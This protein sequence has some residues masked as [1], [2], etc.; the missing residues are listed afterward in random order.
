[1]SK[2][3]NWFCSKFSSR[4][5]LGACKFSVSEL[6]LAETPRKSFPERVLSCSE[7][8]SS[9]EQGFVVVSLSDSSLQ[10][11]TTEVAVESSSEHSQGSN[12]SCISQSS[13]NT[14]S[15]CSLVAM[16]DDHGS[17]EYQPPTVRAISPSSPLMQSHCSLIAV[18]NDQGSIEY[19]PPS[20]QF[21]TASSIKRM[22]SP[23]CNTTSGLTGR[24]HP[25]LDRLISKSNL[26]L[27]PTAPR[28]R[29][30]N[31]KKVQGSFLSALTVV[32]RRS[33]VAKTAGKSSTR[34][35][36]SGSSP[37][38]TLREYCEEKQLELSADNSTDFSISHKVTGSILS[39]KLTPSS[40]VVD[41]QTEH[42][43]AIA[44]LDKY[45]NEHMQWSERK[46]RST[47]MWSTSGIHI[48]PLDKTSNQFTFEVSA[49]LQMHGGQHF[50]V[51]GFSIYF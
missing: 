41:P 49:L 28:K 21:I 32:K 27:S 15:H 14:Q 51:N 47:S 44:E 35:S 10:Q 42:E 6:C 30:S 26:D 24:G 2:K 25:K 34:D 18:L 5:K 20:T 37:V 7:F 11:D 46:L 23:V 36:A 22:S 50:I 1:M 39:R 33:S 17:M 9:L 19:H 16:L 4:N 12:S 43:L 3:L 38:S 29:V 48:P 13:S 45:Y 40:S 8:C 31:L